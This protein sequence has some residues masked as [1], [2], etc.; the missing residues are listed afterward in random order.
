MSD[1][2]IKIEQCKNDIAALQ[3]VLVKLQEVEKRNNVVLFDGLRFHTSSNKYLLLRDGLDWWQVCNDLSFAARTPT[4][5][6]T[7][8]A[9]GTWIQD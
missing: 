5:I 4:E 1:N 3:A 9:N 6:K 8:F 7:F 2:S